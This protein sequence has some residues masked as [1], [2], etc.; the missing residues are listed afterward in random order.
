MKARLFGG[1]A[2]GR[3]QVLAVLLLSVAVLFVGLGAFV[4]HQ[5]LPY[6]GFEFGGGR[7]IGAVVPNSPA[8]AAGLQAGDVVL[9]M[10]GITYRLG[11]AYLRPGQE[12]LRLTVLR[13]GATILI[14][15]ALATPS[16]GER[17]ITSSQYLVALAFWLVAMAV[18]LF[19]P[20]NPE[21]QLFAVMAHLVAAAL[22][23]WS[24][25][26]LGLDWANLSM[27]AV[28]GFSGP[29]FVHFH[30][31]FPERVAF[32]GKKALV[33]GLYGV[34]AVLV[35]AST[36]LDVAA[37]R[38]YGMDSDTLPTLAPVVEAFFSVCVLVGIGLLVRAYFVTTSEKS[39][40]RAAVVGLG[41]LL[42]LLPLVSLIVIPQLFSVPYLLPTWVNMLLL[43]LIP[44]AYAYALYRPD[45]IRLDHAVN[46]SVVFY[47]LV[48]I[49]GSLYLFLSLGIRRLVPGLSAS[50]VTATDVGIFI[51]GL[52]AWQPVRQR[53]QVFVDRALYGGWY[54]YQSFISQSSEGL[55]D[56]IEVRDV[57]DLLDRWVVGT[58]R[59][60]SLALL[61]PDADKETYSVRSSQGFG[62]VGKVDCAGAICQALGALGRPVDHGRLERELKGNP[63]AM[64]ELAAWS[65]A[66]ARV[67]VPL[68][69]QGELMGLM[70][71][72][73]KAADDFVTQGDYDILN[74]LAH[75]VAV[76]LR[77]L[78]LV[79]ELQGQMAEIRALGRQLLVLQERNQHRLAQDLHDQVMQDVFVVRHVL[80]QALESFIPQEIERARKILLDMSGHLRAFIF[81]L[82]PPS[83][84]DTDLPGTLQ[85]YTLTFEE[86]RGIVVDFRAKGED[87]GERMPEEVRTALF[88]IMQESLNNAAK[89]AKVE[90]VAVSLE[91]E[92]GRVRLE[93]SDDGQGFEV[94]PH[95]GGFVGQG[96]LGLVGMRERAEKLGGTCRVESAP[97]QGTKVVVEVPLMVA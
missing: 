92:P 73:S 29:V 56:A 35:L 43:V 18:L 91:L 65:Q 19:R 81:E 61:L 62:A 31:L 70:V 64:E 67:W 2:R 89:H 75:Q 14:E 23:L 46:R 87:P 11:S 30:T 52:A 80:E 36:A 54:D 93:V 16:L 60:R 34:A 97:G 17:F 41:A 69:Q 9:S 27:V 48:V 45:L 44:L 57:S 71:L 79:D 68:V 51:G 77:G 6:A 47:L 88:R 85:D 49:L 28:V 5:S 63:G 8:E 74:T 72:G 83:W 21:T 22:V 15:I 82:R 40:R 53:T 3:L 4:Y 39:R 55:R 66:G 90:Q 26:D 7:T 42:A 59:F 12:M 58:M 13:E 33:V 24:L 76:A 20:R 95:L 1:Q 32:R 94:P 50:V 25:A 38:M 10:A 96:R 37:Y 86:R 84:N 78:R